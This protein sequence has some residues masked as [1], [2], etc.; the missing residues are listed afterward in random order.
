ME[1]RGL[2]LPRAFVCNLLSFLLANQPPIRGNDS[3]NKPA[4]LVKNERCISCYLRGRIEQD[5]RLESCS[6][7]APIARVCSAK[8]VDEGFHSPVASHLIKFRG[9]SAPDSGSFPQAASGL[10]SPV[11]L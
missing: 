11:V 6:F 9:R 5:G 1:V 2:N 3:S 4:Q 7:V 10:V 8:A